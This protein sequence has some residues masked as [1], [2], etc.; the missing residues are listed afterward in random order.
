MLFPGVP[1]AKPRGPELRRLIRVCAFG[2][3][4]SPKENAYRGD[5]YGSEFGSSRIPEVD[6]KR[7][8][9][10]RGCVVLE[11]VGG[12][13]TIMQCVAEF[14]FVSLEHNIW[15][16]ASTRYELLQTDTRTTTFVRGAL[17]VIPI[18]FVRY[19]VITHL[20]A[21]LRIM[22]NLLRNAPSVTNPSA[23]CRRHADSATALPAFEP[24]ST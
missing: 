2:S 19:S 24:S 3:D 22:S 13:E 8:S 15:Q 23:C 17:R 21:F 1:T 20:H 14:M 16:C 7:G 9:S 4:A 18:E 12:N 11:T 10:R 5:I 6:M